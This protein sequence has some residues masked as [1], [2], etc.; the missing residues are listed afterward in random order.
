M[1][2]CEYTNTF[3]D[4]IQIKLGLIEYKEMM[5]KCI[6]KNRELNND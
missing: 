6:A 3:T 5:G 4:V 2:L 1:P